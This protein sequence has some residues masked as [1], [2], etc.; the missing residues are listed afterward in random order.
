MPKMQWPIK[1]LSAVSEQRSDA[2]H[3]RSLLDRNARKTNFL[4]IASKSLLKYVR[5]FHKAKHSAIKRTE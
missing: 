2:N 3:S 4:S 5:E 1:L